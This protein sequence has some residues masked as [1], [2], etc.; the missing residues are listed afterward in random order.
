MSPETS[1]KLKHTILFV[2]IAN[3]LYFIVEFSVALSIGSVSLFAD[4]VDFFEDASVNFLIFLAL[5]WSLKMRA[6]LGMVLAGLLLWPAIATIWMAWH[7]FSTLVPPEPLALSITGFGALIVNFICASLLVRYKNQSGSLTK[8][9]FLSARNDALTNVAII[10]AGF[11]TMY[12]SSALPDI[13]VGIG[14]VSI[15]V[16][17]AKE[18]WEASRKE[19]LE[20]EC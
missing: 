11:A 19:R 12:T 13:I 16:G 8:A 3:F 18:V 7:K 1:S 17:A 10:L 5:G 14:I 15:N 20:A 2:A 4:S 6:R 9:A